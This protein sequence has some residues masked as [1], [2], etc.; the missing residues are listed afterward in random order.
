M[1]V[2]DEM[3]ELLMI[4]LVY[5]LSAVFLWFPVLLYHPLLPTRHSDTLEI[6]LRAAG[7]M[8]LFL[9]GYGTTD[10]AHGMEVAFLKHIRWALEEVGTYLAGSIVSLCPWVVR[11]TFWLVGYGDENENV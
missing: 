1:S 11:H 6:P 7:C 10:M 5:G 4:M 3:V 2:L 8:F 9:L